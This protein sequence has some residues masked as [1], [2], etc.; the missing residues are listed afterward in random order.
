MVP[1]RRTDGFF[2]FIEGGERKTEKQPGER[3]NGEAR[4]PCRRW[5]GGYLRTEDTLPVASR[6]TRFAHP[7]H[8]SPSSQAMPA[9][10]VPSARRARPI[11]SQFQRH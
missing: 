3:R 2:F 4:R 6:S 1:L 7:R 10:S 8:A 5:F 11:S 9:S